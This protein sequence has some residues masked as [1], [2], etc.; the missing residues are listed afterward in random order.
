MARGRR[1]LTPAEQRAWRAFLRAH[2][3]LIGRLNRQL[4]AESGLSLSDYEVLVNLS[5]APERRLRVFELGAAMQWEKSRV[6]H[7]LT[8]MQQRG[9]VVREECASDAR[10]AVVVLTE[11]GRRAI[12]SAAPRH[13]DEVRQ[14]F[15]EPLSSDQLDDLAGAAEAIVA[16]LEGGGRAGNS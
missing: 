11:E 13:V 5:E 6:S 9:L 12:E 14:W 1:W 16:R 15:V 2:T 10:G 4:Q 3:L 7:H 8:R